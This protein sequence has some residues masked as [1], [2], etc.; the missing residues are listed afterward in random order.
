MNVLDWRELK[1]TIDC[2]LENEDLLV[3]V[4]N[5]M[6][7]EFRFVC[8][9]EI[10]DGNVVLNNVEHRGEPAK[11]ILSKKNFLKDDEVWIR[12]TRQLTKTSGS[13]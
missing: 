7:L 8:V 3:C 11:I 10:E 9:P 1:W 6:G 13:R 5:G 2:M 12:V 4:N